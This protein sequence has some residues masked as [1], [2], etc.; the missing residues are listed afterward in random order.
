V[1]SVRCSG[2]IPA[3]A[4]TI[5][6]NRFANLSVF[7]EHRTLNTLTPRIR[8]GLD[9]ITGLCRMSAMKQ[10]D[11][12]HPGSRIVDR[13][14]VGGI[15]QDW[16][17]NT[18]RYISRSWRGPVHIQAEGVD[19]NMR[20]VALHDHVGRGRYPRHHHP[21]SEFIL[22]LD[23]TGVID[24]DLRE[25]SSVTVKPGDLF[26]FP[27]RTVHQSIWTLKAKDTWRLL[28]VDFDIG[29]EVAHM[30]LEEGGQV[31]LGFG[32]FYEWF[33]AGK[34]IHLV[35]A[36]DA[37]RQTSAV[38]ANI[39]AAL[40]RPGYGVGGNLLADVLQ[41]IVL[42]SRGVREQGLADGRNL[43]SPLFSRQAALLKARTLME[44]RSWFDPGCVGR[45]ARE[46]GMAETHFIREF[47]A[48]YGLSP[49]Q[50]SQRILM[51]RAC[52]LLTNT[53]LPVKDIAVRLGYE[54]SSIFS[55][56]FT[57]NVGTSPATFRRQSAT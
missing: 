18:V 40:E 48:A 6:A 37:W 5:H 42:F 47:H 23:G 32:P 44:H 19:F 33:F 21:H 38:A 14:P 10:P 45:L 53:D 15:V 13:V 7:P 22:V 20:Y 31:D 12:P 17:S 43:T 11:R 28:M 49:K 27:P 3:D 50:Y 52:A 34:G 26:V 16:P 46:V 4:G 55:R 1:F 56:A 39:T 24:T 29:L 9:A 36:G 8:F 25:F 35:M 57:R 30:P 41:L 2:K 54:D 51:R